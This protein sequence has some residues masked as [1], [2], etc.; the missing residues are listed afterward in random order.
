LFPA[1]RQ[2]KLP[3]A[4]ATTTYCLRFLPMNVIGTECAGASSFVSHNS[5]PFRASNARKYPSMV[6]SMKM[7]PPSRRS[8]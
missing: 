8:S 6:A 3:P 5:F 1:V 2:E 7:T 4:A